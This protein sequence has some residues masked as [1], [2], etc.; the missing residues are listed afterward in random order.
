MLAWLIPLAIPPAA[1]QY[2][3]LGLSQFTHT[4][5][6]TDDGVPAT[7]VGSLAQTPDGWLWISSA[8]GLFRFDGVAFE[9]IDPPV[10]S[11]M[12]RASPR[13]LFVTR[14]GELWV[15]YA[16]GGGIAAYRGGGLRP[17][18]PP[19]RAM[20]LSVVAQTR[21]GAIWAIG[22][23]YRDTRFH[24]WFGGKWESLDARLRAPEGFAGEVCETADGSVWTSLRADDRSSFFSLPPGAAQLRPSPIRT[25]GMVT[26]RIDPKGR[27][28]IADK[29]GT[30]MVV[31]AD[32]RLIERPIVFPAVPNLDAAYLAFDAAGGL[33]GGTNSTGIFYIPDADKPRRTVADRLEQFVAADG[34]TSDGVYT[35]FVDREGNIWF[36]SDAGLNRF[37]PARALRERSIPGDAGQGYAI[38]G[39]GDQVFVV[40]TAGVFQ[41]GRGAPRRLLDHGVGGICPAREG[42]FW[43][44]RDFEI[45]HVRAGKQ[46]SL[47][48][49]AGGGLTGSCVEDR[50]GRLWASLY[51]GGAMWRDAGGWHRLRQP[52]PDVRWPDLVLTTAGDAAY[53]TSDAL[54]TLRPEGAS[55]IAL[56]P[57]DLGDIMKL[58][59]GLRDIFISG[60]NGL[61]RVRGNRVDRIDARRFPWVAR[62]RGLVQTPS[63]D[64]W[65]RR[66]LWVSRVST[67]DL[68]RAFEDPSAHLPRTY[69]DLRD[70]VIPA[71]DQTFTGPQ[72]TVGAEGRIWLP[73]RQ[74][75]GYIDPGKGARDAAPPPLVIRSLASGGTVYRDPGTVTLSAGTRALEIGYAALSYAAPH[76]VEFRYRLEGVDE[77]WVSAGTRRLASYTNLGP[78]KYRFEV[79]ATNGDGVWNSKGATLAFEIPPTFVQGWP[80]KL[81]CGLVVLGL[82]WLAYSMR[83]RTV[84]NRIR[85]RLAARVE[86]RERIARDLHDTLLQSVQALTL[87]FQLVVD[88]LPIAE[89][90]RPALEAAIDRA[91]QTIAEGRDRVLALRSL[92]E[93]PDIAA[94]LADL[95]QRQG[96]DASV[97][98]SITAEGTPRPIAPPVL[99]EVRYLAGE[100]IFNI[101]RHA[102]ATQVAIE[103][104]YRDDFSLRLRDNG[105]GIDPE[106]ARSGAAGHFG[107]AGMRERARKLRGT[108]GVRRLPEG[109]TEILL[110]VPGRVAYTPARRRGLFRFWRRQGPRPPAISASSR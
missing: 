16:Q 36:A 77:D 23:G 18:G 46:R 92:Q 40:T 48:L 61:L 79:M 63:G 2:A 5:W 91:D 67:A 35:P 62:L 108:L 51:Q 28:W 66:A 71:L 52:L 105:V 39:A 70:G 78:G 109:G 101:W 82:L 110:S 95:V 81:L 26:C 85:A 9:R 73:D 57:F 64:T 37:R 13:S 86:E 100:A 30:R 69:Y 24:R 19:G 27:M 65:L 25:Y 15:S 4:R 1:A 34:L 75:L 7:G 97:C 106:I 20:S 99:D 53:V 102:C 55:T 60:N 42:G 6:T 107:L 87:R 104:G 83:L 33:W 72:V 38:A 49:P 14:S 8:E 47:P 93:A 89:R 68:D 22:E 17:V 56:A 103:I 94:I 31:G 3:R 96:F 58:S 44:V 12:E 98:I 76:R 29:G 43:A 10:G 21:D 11:P 50:S 80:F 84:A 32:G 59:N 90:A 41:L 45:L 74:G 54:V 88:E